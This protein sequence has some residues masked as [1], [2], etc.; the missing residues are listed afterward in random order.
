MS[1]VLVNVARVTFALSLVG[2]VVAGCGR[3]GDLDRP[4]TPVE[5]QNIRKTTKPGEQKKSEPV[6][7]KPF[8]LDPLL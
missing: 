3:K 8:V 4:S 7:E 2:I 6:A 5:Q 1:K